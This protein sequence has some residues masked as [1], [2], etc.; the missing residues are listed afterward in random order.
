MVSQK[1]KKKGAWLGLTLVSAALAVLGAVLITSMMGVGAALLAVGVL[2]AAIGVSGLMRAPTVAQVQAGAPTYSQEYVEIASRLQDF[3]SEYGIRNSDFSAALRELKESVKTLHSLRSQKEKY[4]GETAD[5]QAEERTHGETVTAIFAEYA[6]TE[7]TYEMAALAADSYAACLAEWEKRKAAAEE[8]CAEYGITEEPQ[9]A[10]DMDGLKAALAAAQSQERVCRDE[11]A[12]MERKLAALPSLKNEL[13]SL[14]EDLA[15]YK[16]ERE[17]LAVAVQSLTDADKNLKDTYLTPMQTSFVRF[18]TAMGAEWAN[19]VSLD[20]GLQVQFEYKGQPR[21]AE[22]FSD[23]QR[24]LVA[25]CMRLALLDNM[26]KGEM[27]FCI[28]DDPF[29]HLDEKHFAEVQKGLN[30]LAEKMQIL[31]FTCHKS[32]S[33]L[34]E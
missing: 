15:G 19:V 23:G 9:P 28:L 20:E 1:P 12:E 29:V 2:G 14:N 18:A 11:L 24:A 10:G 6:L 13:L 4:E 17:L 31:Y 16:A 34:E 5:L 8:Y 32:R 3:F 7:E 22:H 25:L 27:P 21:R 26:Y 30:A 33:M